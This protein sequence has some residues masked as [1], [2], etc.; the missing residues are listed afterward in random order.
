MAKETERMLQY[1]AGR[2]GGPPAMRSICC[3]LRNEIQS[4]LLHD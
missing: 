4:F 3:S 1:L 2:G